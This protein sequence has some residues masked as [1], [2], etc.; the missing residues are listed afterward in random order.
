MNGYTL[1][2]TKPEGEPYKLAHSTNSYR[3][4]CMGAVDY[5]NDYQ[6]GELP[7]LRALHEAM[8][9]APPG[10]WVTHESGHSFMVKEAV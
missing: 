10:T 6:L 4:V 7:D 5:L 1:W 3:A 2:H 8:V 9:K